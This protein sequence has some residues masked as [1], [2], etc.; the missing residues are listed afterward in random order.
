M[1]ELL[2]PH[3]A[4]EKVGVHPKTLARWAV[5]GLIGEH[6]TLGGHRRYDLDEIQRVVADIE[7]THKK[8]IPRA[9]LVKVLMARGWSVLDISALLREVDGESEEPAT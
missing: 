3:D 6:R 9:Q 5:R 4:A 8:P 7:S 2:R 1:V